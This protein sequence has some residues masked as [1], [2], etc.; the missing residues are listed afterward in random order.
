MLE[1]KSQGDTQ[2][3]T[4]SKKRKGYKNMKR[5]VLWRQWTKDNERSE[6][7]H[8]HPG[9]RRWTQVGVR[10]RPGTRSLYHERVTKTGIRSIL[11]PNK[12]RNGIKRQHYPG[13]DVRKW[14]PEFENK[15]LSLSRFPSTKG[16]H[17][18]G[19]EKVQKITP[20]K[21]LKSLP[22]E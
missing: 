20:S 2:T 4:L 7:N 3:R 21:T 18:Q 6:H 12:Q 22:R 10:I 1:S 16:S 19:R 8:P 5:V 11:I 15:V 13:V 17:R 14:E 9:K